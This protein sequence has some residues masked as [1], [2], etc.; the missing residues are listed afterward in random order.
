MTAHWFRFSLVQKF[1]FYFESYFLVGH[2]IRMDVVV[3]IMER[4]HKHVEAGA[5]AVTWQ[6]VA[7]I[8][9]VAIVAYYM[10][11]YLFHFKVVRHLYMG[12][13]IILIVSFLHQG[14]KGKA[15]ADVFKLALV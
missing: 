12:L 15:A 6:Q 13:L 2:T 14:K 1:K 4:I 8:A 9:L 11:E 5:G 10:G 3:D 7:G